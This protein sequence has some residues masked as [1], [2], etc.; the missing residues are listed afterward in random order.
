ML[1]QETAKGNLISA[2][3]SNVVDFSGGKL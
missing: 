1:G 2:P 3:V